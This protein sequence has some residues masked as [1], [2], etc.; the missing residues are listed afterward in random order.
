[1]LE[2][3]SSSF[4]TIA[5]RQEELAVTATGKGVSLPLFHE[6]PMIPWNDLRRGRCC[7][8]FESQSDGYYCKLCDLFVHEKCGELSDSIHL[9]PIT[10]S[11]FDIF[12]V[13]AVLYVEDSLLNFA[14]V[15]RRVSLLWI[16]TVP[17]I[18]HHEM[19]LTIWRRTITSSHF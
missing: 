16:Y 1:M 11:S 13:L 8:C 15:V 19:L 5:K 2:G 9:T 14:M 7:D 10:L 6:H 12:Q 18:H 4:L 3:N 17:S